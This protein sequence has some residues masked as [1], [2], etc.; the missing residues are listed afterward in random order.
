MSENKNRVAGVSNELISVIMA[1]YNAENTL[2]ESIQSA[3]GQSYKNLELIVV[4]DASTDATLSIA[5]TFAR[6]D[7]RVRVIP[8]TTNCGV[9]ASRKDGLA[10]AK[11]RWVAILDSDDLW[12]PEKLEMQLS[13]QRET[14]AD[15]I[16]TASAFIDEAGIR[17]PWCMRVP[18]TVAYRSLLKQNIISNSS[19]LV[20]KELFETYFVNNDSMHEDFAVWLRMLKDGAVVRGVDQPLLIYRIRTSSKS[21]DKLKSAVMSWNTYRYVGLNI[22]VSCYYMA[23][24]A[25]HGFFKYWHL[26]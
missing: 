6:R 21:G 18:K 16:Y 22:P 2:A 13:A 24:Y 7:E 11:G 5:R 19:V 10:N 25:I 23:C 8:H 12:L 17:K 20:R 4:D 26:K 14:N 1:A 9:S 15:L 3:L